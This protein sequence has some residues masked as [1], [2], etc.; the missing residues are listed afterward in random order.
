MNQ[1]PGSKPPVAHAF[2]VDQLRSQREK[3]GDTYLPFLKVPSMRMGIYALDAGADDEQS[4][5]EE[6]EVYYV[7]S[8]RGT[9]R[10]E[11]E[12]HPVQAGSLVFVAA[13]AAHKF[14]SITEALEVLV[15]FPAAAAPPLPR[16]S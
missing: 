16:V 13:R 6:D 3:S 12:E 15:F 8:G 5:H 14:H 11:S 10:V 7:L 9:R 4:P 2:S 1:D